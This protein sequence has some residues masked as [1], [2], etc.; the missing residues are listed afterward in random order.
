[1]LNERYIF[2][3]MNFVT[4]VISVYTGKTKPTKVQ[5][6]SNSFGGGFKGNVF[7]IVGILVPV[8]Y[9]VFDSLGIVQTSYQE[10]KEFVRGLPDGATGYFI[11]NSGGGF[12]YGL[13]GL[14]EVI[15]EAREER[16]VKLISVIDSLCASAAYLIASNTDYIYASRLSSVGSIGVY[17]VFFDVSEAVRGAGL[18]FHLVSS[19][20]L[21]G[22]DLPEQ[23]KSNEFLEWEQRNID[24]IFRWVLGNMGR[25]VNDEMKNGGIIVG[26]RAV[27][28][29]LVDEL[30]ENIEDL[31]KEEKDANIEEVINEEDNEG[32][33][34]NETEL[35]TNKEKIL[36]IVN[37]DVIKY[38]LSKGRVS[39]EYFKSMSPQDFV[40][41][42]NSVVKHKG[43]C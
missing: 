36:A 35:R 39:L 10:I 15:R 2:A 32:E 23:P 6:Y 9:D 13:D 38:D 24:D 33:E 41:Y 3:D 8:R 37:G 1:M 12:V 30:Y 26:L 28:Y 19:G 31:F 17:S 42:F 40:R 43:G 7:P 16:G 21:K 5:S 14:L 25:E 18:K 34:N 11:F 22:L 4:D 20:S 29:G 27:S